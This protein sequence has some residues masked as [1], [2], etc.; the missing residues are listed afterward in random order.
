MVAWWGTYT[1]LPMHTYPNRVPSIDEYVSPN[2]ILNRCHK[3][4]TTVQ[5]NIHCAPPYIYIYILHAS[6]WLLPAQVPS[7]MEFC[8][9][10]IGMSK[11][12]KNRK[13]DLLK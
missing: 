8:R 5:H 10:A 11:G 7:H 2:E 1:Y 9:A 3:P 13:F 12:S 4:D 6:G